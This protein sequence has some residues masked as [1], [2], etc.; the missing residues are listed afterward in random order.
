MVETT[1]IDWA[2]GDMFGLEFPAHPEA[3][4]SGGPDFLTRAFRKSGMLEPNNSVTRITGLDEWTLGGT[5]VKAHLSVEYERD[6]PGLSPDLFV[7][8]S[9]NF[10]DKVRDSGRHHMPPEVRLANLSRDPGFPIAVPR[11][12]FADIEQE[13]LTGIIISERIPYGRGAIEQHQP[14]CMDQILPDP[15]AHYSALVLNLARLSGAYKAGRLGDVAERYFP[16]D[17]ETMIAR[18]PRFDAPLLIKRISRL[19]D[20]LQQYR[21]LV[22]AHI[23]DPAFLEGF[24]A[25]AAAAVD[26]QDEIWSYLYSRPDMIALCHMNANVDNAWFWREP[27]GTLQSGLIDWGSVGQMSVASSIWGCIG[28]AEP[29]MH[30]RHLG[31]LLDLFIAEYA[32]VGG[33]T[34]DRDELEQHLEMHVMMS[35]LHMTTA[36]PAILREIPDPGAVPDRYDPAFT[37]NETARVQLK[38]TI[39]LLNMW[40]RHDLGRHLRQDADWR[41]QIR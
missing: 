10:Q 39:S 37:A 28:A 40:Q 3:L 31:D 18:R 38:I 4:K 13:T 1:S 16:L 6:V 12:F 23:A 35:A 29:D 22:P 21:H 30:D 41:R 15:F 27:D 25:G 36:P 24:K 26:H 33:P 20:F 2:R 34:L 17:L 9:R 32:R 8:F 14:K 5:G 11:C 19:A 7:K